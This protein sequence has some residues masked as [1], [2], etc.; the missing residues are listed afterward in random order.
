M[1][2][3]PEGIGAVAVIVTAWAILGGGL[4]L[5]VVLVNVGA[6][7]AA[8]AGLS[9]PGD[10][11]LTEMGVAVAAFAFLPYCQLTRSNV[12]A[13]IFTQTIGPRFIAFLN[14]LASAVALG[15]S[16]LLLWRMLAG[17]QD[18]KLYN[19]ETSILQIPVW[20]AYIPV[21]ISLALLALAAATT[22]KRDLNRLAGKAGDRD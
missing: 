9:L 7:M 1:E 13:D 22:L 10:F 20:L 18:Q 19:Y 3:R 2:G 21:L 14:L 8:I 11:E 6:V 15:F 12:T 4:L 17:L 16:L 5:L